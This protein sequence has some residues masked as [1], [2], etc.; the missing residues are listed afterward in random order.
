MTNKRSML[1]WR[2]KEPRAGRR[3]PMYTPERDGAHIGP[4]IVRW[5]VQSLEEDRWE[6]WLKDFMAKNNITYDTLVE[7]EASRKIALA[8]NQIIRGKWAVD[9]LEESG[10]A[11]MPAE[12]QLIMF[13][14]IGQAFLSFVWAAVKDVSS[15]ED[16]PPITF[17][18][19]LSH[20]EES[21]RKLTG[22]EDAADTD[23]KLAA[24]Q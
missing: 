3:D 7:S 1:Q 12:I 16:E 2:R 14:R 9:S 6:P 13:A 11:S 8:L 4:D 21:F 15:P 17:Q 22:A 24:D 18:D 10:F 19:L 5:A 23:T 20:V